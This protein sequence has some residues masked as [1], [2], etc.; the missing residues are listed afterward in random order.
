VEVE[1]VRGGRLA[2]PGEVV[3][4]AT[5]GSRLDAWRAQMAPRVTDGTRSAREQECLSQFFSVLSTRLPSV[6]PCDDREDF[7]RTN[8]DRERSIR[9]RTMPSRRISGRTNGNASLVHDGRCLASAACW[10]HDATHLHQVEPRAAPLDRAR[11]RPRP[12]ETTLA[13]HEHRTRVRFRHTRQPS[14]H[15]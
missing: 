4:N 14:L 1:P 5:V 8:T 7:P 15:S 3:S 9:G 2:Q 12:Q 11:G 13:H 10:E 6:V